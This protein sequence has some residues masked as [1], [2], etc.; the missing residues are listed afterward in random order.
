MMFLGLLKNG[1]GAY[2]AYV[3]ITTAGA[4]F[5]RIALFGKRRKGKSKI[6]FS[7]ASSQK[8][9]PIHVLELES[10]K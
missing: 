6:L 9:N 7:E 4:T 3:R 5:K 1:N 8:I 2:E 10:T